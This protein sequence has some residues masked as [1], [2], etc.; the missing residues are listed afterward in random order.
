VCLRVVFVCVPVT[1]LNKQK[2]A[3]PQDPDHI[4]S[5]EETNDPSLT[6]QDPDHIISPAVTKD[7][8][9]QL[10]R[11]I[12][13]ISRSPRDDASAGCRI[14]ESEPISLSGT[15]STIDPPCGDCALVAS[16]PEQCYKH[17]AENCLGNRPQETSVIIAGKT[18]YPQPPPTTRSRTSTTTTPST[19]QRRPTSSSSFHLITR[20]LTPQSR[21]KPDPPRKKR[22]TRYPSTTG[23]T[24]R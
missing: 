17:I 1:A 13:T 24:P 18:P 20:V 22:G 15:S 8:S 12:A 11:K 2:P 21:R 3:Q 5:P 14:A 16:S 10:P 4:R 23:R 7:P 9:T 19:T 6:Q